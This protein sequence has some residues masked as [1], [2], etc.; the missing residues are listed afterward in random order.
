M[1]KLYFQRKLAII[2]LKL[3]QQPGVRTLNSSNRSKTNPRPVFREYMI[4]IY[5]YIYKKNYV[6]F[7]VSII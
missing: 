1:I 4:R 3:T 2:V 5:I 7:L 6:A